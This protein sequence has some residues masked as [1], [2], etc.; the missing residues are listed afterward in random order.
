MEHVERA[1]IVVVSNI[2]YIA[3]GGIYDQ[4]HIAASSLLAQHTIEIEV[5]ILRDP[6]AG[7]AIGRIGQVSEWLSA[8]AAV[9]VPHDDDVRGSF[10]G[11][12]IERPPGMI[13]R[14][15]CAVRMNRRTHRWSI[16]AG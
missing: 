8:G 10:A 11:A 14:I 13:N 15:S 7:V 2:D 16:L 12:V 3:V 5:S 9:I 1:V 6:D 4:G